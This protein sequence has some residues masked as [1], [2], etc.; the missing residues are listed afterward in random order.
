ML[1]RPISNAIRDFSTEANATVTGDGTALADLLAATVRAA[2]NDEAAIGML[3]G[4]AH[5]LEA[6]IIGEDHDDRRG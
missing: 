5:V 2:A 3:Y 1:Q 4:L 6:A